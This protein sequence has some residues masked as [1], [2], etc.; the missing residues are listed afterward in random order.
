MR[1]A[2]LVSGT[3]S[4]LDSMLDRGIEVTLVLADRPCAALARVEGRV[5]AVELLER[6]EWGRGFDRE[7]YT[8]RLVE[9]LD[10]HGIDLVA[11]AGF[12]TV[13][14]PALFER[15]PGRVLNTHPALLP[16][17]PGWHSVRQALEAGV[18]VTG[19]TVH[20]ATAEVDSG[21][22]L[23]QAAV[24]VRTGDTEESL[25]ERIK[26]VERELYPSTLAA[27]IEELDTG[28]APA[29]GGIR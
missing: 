24:E 16:S 13:L 18:K 14:G 26:E 15:F 28:D 11:M 19:C 2:V 17:F 22:I 12:G 29:R 9:S 20:I 4:I 21:P 3:G 27:F 23:A 5:A 10:A 7:A 8:A 1:L 6:G 25:H